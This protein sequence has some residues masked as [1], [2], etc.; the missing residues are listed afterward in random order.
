MANAPLPRLAA[1]VSGRGTN[2]QAIVDAIADGVLEAELVGVFSDRPDAAALARVPAALR[3]SD[4]PARH[5]T[6]ADFDRALGDAV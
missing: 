4:T 1:L 5:A 6:R 3:W 2:L